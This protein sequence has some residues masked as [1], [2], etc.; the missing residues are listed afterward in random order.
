MGVAD[1]IEG[2]TQDLQAGWDTVL[3]TDRFVAEGEVVALTAL[4][5]PS[6]VVWPLTLQ[7]ALG[8][9]GK[10]A[11]ADLD[12]TSVRLSVGRRTMLYPYGWP[13]VGS[14]G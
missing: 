13:A 5:T 9:Q 2:K 7:N 10:I 4:E 8:Y 14:Y 3:A 12:Q 6:S 11:P 1:F